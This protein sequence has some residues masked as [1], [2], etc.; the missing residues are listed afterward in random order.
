MQEVQISFP[1]NLKP[2]CV[3]EHIYITLHPPL[4]HAVPP[5]ARLGS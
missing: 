4:A 2:P 5:L 1:P 3:A